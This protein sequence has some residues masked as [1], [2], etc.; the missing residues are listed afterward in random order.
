MQQMDQPGFLGGFE[1]GLA[2]RQVL[3]TEHG[4]SALGDAGPMFKRALRIKSEPAGQGVLA[5][6]PH[7]H[8]IAGIGPVLGL[9]TASCLLGADGGLLTLPSR[10]LTRKQTDGFLEDGK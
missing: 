4:L 5:G 1:V 10:E 9:G 3:H 7:L 2:G 6:R 8:L